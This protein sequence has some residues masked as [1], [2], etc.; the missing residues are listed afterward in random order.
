MPRLKLILSASVCSIALSGCVPAA[1][2]LALSAVS[3]M[4]GG[5]GGNNGKAFRNPMDTQSTGRQVKQALSR[6]NDSVDPACQAMLDE[7]QSMKGGAAEK[8]AAPASPASE[9]DAPQAPGQPKKAPVNL[10][11]K[12]GPDVSPETQDVARSDDTAS[13]GAEL[14]PAVA[15]PEQA[16]QAGAKPVKTA[17]APVKNAAP[18]QCE[19]RLVCLPGTPKPTLMLMCPGKGGDGKDG[20]ATVVSDAP[21]ETQGEIQGEIQGEAASPSAVDAGQPER[22]ETAASVTAAAPP[23]TATATAAAA[24]EAEPVPAAAHE[25]G[26]ADWNWAYD[27]A[28]RL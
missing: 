15:S 16:E 10:L 25:R 22:Q 17:L 5:G 9:A 7:R 21:G 19:H 6:L 11:A 3:L 27:P 28:K 4:T 8:P 2:G 13:G 20:K 24:T 18:G 23:A 12:L 14:Q 26:V 1:A